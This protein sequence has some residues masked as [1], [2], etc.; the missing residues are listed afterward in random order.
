M[1]KRNKIVPARMIRSGGYW[2]ATIWL[3]SGLLAG[4]LQQIFHTKNFVDIFVHL[5]YP[6]YFMSILGAWKIL[7]V[8]AILI[9]GFKL[10]KEWAYAGSFFVWSGAV[11]SHIAIG[12]PM[13]EIFP[14]LVLL[15]LTV[16]SWYFRPE[17]RKIISINQ[18]VKMKLNVEES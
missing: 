8:I 12:D 15:I 14:G 1:N 17:N 2:I 7:S 3:A 5:G 10:L 11:F 13:I 18:K 4:G 9:P 6:L 16:V